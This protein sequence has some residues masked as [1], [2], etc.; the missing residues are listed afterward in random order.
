VIRIN[1]MRN[2]GVDTG[3]TTEYSEATSFGF[4]GGEGGSG[5][6]ATAII[7]ILLLL[8]VTGALLLYENQNISALNAKFAI[9]IQKQV[10]MNTEIQKKQKEADKLQGLQKEIKELRAKVD[11][12]RTLSK[13]RLREIKALDFLQNI[14]PERVW[15]TS[16]IYA[17]EKLTLRGFAV[18]EEN[19]TDFTSVM[20]SKP[21]FSDVLLLQAKESKLGSIVSQ[22]FEI[23]SRLEI[24]D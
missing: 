15:L 7:K 5:D 21:Y 13:T 6:Q 24:V 9:I 14:I 20:E 18:Q 22:E 2:R 8:L 17:N 16:L 3:H 12:L 11:I 23:T 10:K 19:L 4:G 1:L